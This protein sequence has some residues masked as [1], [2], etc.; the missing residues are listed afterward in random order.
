MKDLGSQRGSD[1]L[2]IFQKLF[3]LETFERAQERAKE[4]HAEI[5]GQVESQEREIATRA[6]R[7]SKLPELLAGLETHEH[8]SKANAV[9]VGALMRQTDEAGAL[10][11]D[12]QTKHPPHPKG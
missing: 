1:R 9:R 2:L 10:G 4:R 7:V 3:R 8:E 12:P 11:Q 6:E 5:H